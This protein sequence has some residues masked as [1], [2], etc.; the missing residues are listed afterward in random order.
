[1]RGVSLL[2]EGECADLHRLHPQRRPQEPLDG[3]HQQCICGVIKCFQKLKAKWDAKM[4]RIQ[5][6]SQ[7]LEALRE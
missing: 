5:K 1:M 7:K 2:R 6:Y 3:E 4:D